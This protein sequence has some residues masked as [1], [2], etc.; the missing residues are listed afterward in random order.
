MHTHCLPVSKC[1]HHEPELLPHIFKAHGFD[2]IVLTNHCDPV[3]CDRLGP[4]LHE[5]ALSYVDTYERCKKSGDAIDV[6]VFFGVEVKLINEPNQ[7][8][9]L[10]YGISQEDFI[11]SY[12]LYQKTQKELYDY[13]TKNNVILVQAHPFR[14]EQ[15]YAP[16]DMRYV[17]GVEIYNPHLRFNARYDESLKLAQDNKKIKTAGSDFHIDIQAGLSGMIV[18][19]D[20]NDQFMLR[21]F[22]KQNKAVVLCKDG[23]LYK[24]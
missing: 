24:E 19:D 2:A 11:A 4:T 17:D 23:I 21:D 13:C 15:G 8:E 7:P 12:P 10:L 20:I 6:K 1:A 16:A 9:F 14:T 5:Q 22:L 3:D 18:S